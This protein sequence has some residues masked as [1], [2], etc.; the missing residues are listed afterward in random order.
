MVSTVQLTELE[1]F[2]FSRVNPRVTGVRSKRK[3]I[4]NVELSTSLKFGVTF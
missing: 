1:A 4:Q 3:S 2:G